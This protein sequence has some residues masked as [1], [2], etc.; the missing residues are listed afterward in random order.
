M[1][2]KQATI[3]QPLLT[4]GSANKLDFHGSKRIV[5]FCMVGAEIF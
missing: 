4:D 3:Q 1:A 5:D 2:T